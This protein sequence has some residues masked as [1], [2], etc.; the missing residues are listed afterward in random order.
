FWR[1]FME[2]G[3]DWQLAAMTLYE[4]FHVVRFNSIN[5]AVAAYATPPDRMQLLR[6]C[7]RHALEELGHEKMIVKDANAVEIDDHVAGFTEG[8]SDPLPAT[9]AFIA[10]L[11]HTALKEGAIARLGYSYWAENSYTHLND[12]I[13]RGKNDLEAT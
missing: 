5:Q 11:F 4:M 13:Q 8:L 10:Y 3:I 6:Y 1:Y 7:Y 9:R 12:L 2:N